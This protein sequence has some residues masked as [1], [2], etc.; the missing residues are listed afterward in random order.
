M[1]LYFI[2][3]EIVL[4]KVFEKRKMENW[5]IYKRINLLHS[6]NKKKKIKSYPLIVKSSLFSFHWIVAT[7]I[8]ND[9]LDFTRPLIDRSYQ[10]IFFTECYLKGSLIVR[11]FSTLRSKNM[12]KVS[13]GIDECY[14]HSNLVLRKRFEERET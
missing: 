7:P 10:H 11:S 13:P 4:R 2:G 12:R 5:I 9:M 3:L 6:K 14:M 8:W 1:C